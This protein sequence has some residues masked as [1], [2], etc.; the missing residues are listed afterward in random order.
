MIECECGHDIPEEDPAGNKFPESLMDV[1]VQ[2]HERTEHRRCWFC[3]HNRHPECMISMPHHAVFD[4]VTDC[5]FDV[6][7]LPCECVH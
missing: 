7:Y 2:R 3:K 6:K 5:S 4:G 1:M